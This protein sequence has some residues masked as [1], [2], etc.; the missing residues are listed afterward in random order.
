MTVTIFCDLEGVL[1]PEMWPHL[2]KV[3]A[4]EQLSITTRD[5]P[6]YRGLMDTRLRL[7]REHGIGIESVCRAVAA[8]E[9]LP[10]ATAFVRRLEALGNVVIVSDSFRPMNSSLV[11][12]LFVHNIL[13]HEFLIDGDGFIGGCAYWNNLAGKHVCLT[14]IPDSNSPT[15]AIGDA[16]NDLSM[17]RAAT[18]GILFNPSAATLQAAPD[19]EATSSYDIVISRLERIYRHK[20]LA[21][22]GARHPH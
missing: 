12:R 6:D 7:L 4:I 1:T 8:I 13:C 19:L 2:A 18:S 9:P 3:L 21:N 20:P 15:I 17:I 5:I 11:K 10:G 16:F 22:V 14:R